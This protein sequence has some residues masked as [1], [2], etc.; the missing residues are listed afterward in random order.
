MMDP[1]E[2]NSQVKMPIQKT[3][4]TGLDYLEERT[5]WMMMSS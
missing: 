1:V 5:Q 3:K 2:A 4:T